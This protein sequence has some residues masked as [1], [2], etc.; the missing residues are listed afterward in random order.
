MAI[1]PHQER[2][3]QKYREKPGAAGI[4]AHAYKAWKRAIARNRWP[5]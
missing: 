1:N 5:L 3:I 4:F 2:L